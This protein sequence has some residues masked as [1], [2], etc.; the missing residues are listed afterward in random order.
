VGRDQTL[1]ARVQRVWHKLYC[2]P[3]WG[4]RGTINRR[5]CLHATCLPIWWVLFIGCGR[6]G[7]DWAWRCQSLE[8]P[9]E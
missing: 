8:K 3:L 1:M 7:H 2:R 4:R 5:M 6:W 9:G